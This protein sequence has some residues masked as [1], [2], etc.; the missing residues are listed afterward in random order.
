LTE[1]GDGTQ[2]PS[3]GGRDLNRRFVGLATHLRQQYKVQRISAAG[4]LPKELKVSVVT[5]EHFLSSQYWYYERVS[6]PTFTRSLKISSCSFI[7][8]PIKPRVESFHYH[9]TLDGN[10]CWKQN[11]VAGGYNTALKDICHSNTFDD[12]KY[13][14]EVNVRNDPPKHG[15]KIILKPRGKMS[16]WKWEINDEEISNRLRYPYL[17]K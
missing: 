9:I 13:W 8:R 11:G 5:W 6:V 7:E 10:V 4:G 15:G 14:E 17:N 2:N 1:I 12:D 16:S 3:S